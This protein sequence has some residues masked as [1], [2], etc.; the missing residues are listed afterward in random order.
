MMGPMI[1]YKSTWLNCQPYGL[2]YALK[3]HR[4]SQMSMSDRKI[5]PLGGCTIFG[6]GVAEDGR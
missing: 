5:Y 1:L 6:V 3:N 4:N 2:S